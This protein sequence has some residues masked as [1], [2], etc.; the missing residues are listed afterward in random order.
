MLTF[1]H[2]ADLFPLIE[3]AE[4][5]ALA[6][7]IQANGLRDKIVLHGGQILDGR[8]RYRAGVAGGTVPS[9]G[10]GPCFRIFDQAVDGDALAFVLSKNLSR[11]HLN[12][13]QRAM[14]AARLADMRQGERTDLAGPSANLRKVAQTE[15][16][17]KLNVSPRLV[18]SA[19]TVQEK[20]SAKLRHA[21]DTGKLPASAA[22]QAA[23]LPAEEQDAIAERAEAG[24]ANAVRTQIKQGVRAARERELGQKVLA[25]PEQ[26]FGIILADPEWEFVVFSKVTGMDR[27]PANHYATSSEQEI[28]A[29]DVQKIAAKD[30]MLALWVTDLA[31]G[32]RVMEM[33]GFAFKSYFVWVKDVVPVLEQ[34]G[35]PTRFYEQ[36]GAAGLGYWNRD[37]DEICL[38]GTRGDFVAP[39]MGTQPESVIFAAR[40]KIEGTRKGKHSAKPDDIHRWIEANWPNVPKIELNA[41]QARA[42]WSVWGHEAPGQ[43]S[44]GELFERAVA[45]VRES[46]KTSVSYV[47]RQ[48]AITYNRALA[49]MQQLQERGVVTA[50]DHRGQREILPPENP[51]ASKCIADAERAAALADE[52]GMVRVDETHTVAAGFL[53]A[54][55][56]VQAEQFA[57]R[58]E[59]E[60]QSQASD[61]EAA[62]AAGEPVSAA[63]SD[64]RSDPE[65]SSA[66]ARERPMGELPE[67]GEAPRAEAVDVTGG[68]S[69]APEFD[70]ARDLPEFL[71]R[72]RAGGEP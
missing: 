25:L 8:N 12:E 19:R 9:D 45:C 33:W 44:D 35:A 22:A 46:G 36:I 50:P 43:S 34:S 53:T 63:R 30:C 7:D 16:A 71:R 39:A 70:L 1:H 15:A 24:E 29:R 21:V 18:T 62:A 6:A 69:A 5:D 48:L 2:F 56:L 66:T 51:E 3:G 14:V 11:R 32:I 13:S 4:F 27:S 37:R 47:Q 49:L 60:F 54:G 72:P 31:R 65:G 28:S 64:S 57:A 17:S 55:E 23:R 68:E 41:R 42:G 38:I 61:T 40:P 59:S 10:Q 52:N 20:G 58:K 26:K 67:R